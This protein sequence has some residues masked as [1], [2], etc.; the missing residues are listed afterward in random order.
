M[1]SSLNALDSSSPEANTTSGHALMA[2]K[3]CYLSCL[4]TQ[5][6]L[7]NGA[8]DHICNNI[9]CFHSYAAVSGP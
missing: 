3:H 7:D 1:T 8:S 2:G 6:L 9:S 4:D 5:W